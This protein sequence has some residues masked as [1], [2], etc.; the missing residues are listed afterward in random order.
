MDPP[1]F[2]LIPQEHAVVS[3]RHWLSQRIAACIAAARQ[4]GNE[5]QSFVRQRI[6]LDGVDPI[7]WIPDLAIWRGPLGTQREAA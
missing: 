2:E 3:W 4:S 5:V 1:R 6:A 7:N